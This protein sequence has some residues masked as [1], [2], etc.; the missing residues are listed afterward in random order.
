MNRSRE[1]T[2]KCIVSSLTEEGNEL[3]EELSP[4]TGDESAR[5]RQSMQVRDGGD[6]AET[7]ND[8]K[9]M[10]DPIDAPVGQSLLFSYSFQFPTRLERRERWR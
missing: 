9:W 10:P 3:V 1:D 2:I 6:E 8:P 4:V 7:Y 5:Y